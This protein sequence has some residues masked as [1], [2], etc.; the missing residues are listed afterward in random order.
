[1]TPSPV[2]PDP[3]G[4]RL[5]SVTTW[6]QATISM[7]PPLQTHLVAGGRSNLTYRITD[8]DGRR[9]ALR[10]PPA[11]RLLAT[12][13]DMTREWAVLRA[14]QGSDVPVA[15][16]IALCT[17]EAVTGAP[18]YVMAWMDGVVPVGDDAAAALSPAAAH[19]LTEDLADVL[20]AL[21][22]V[23]PDAVGLGDWRRPGDYLQR[24]LKRWHRQVHDSG[25]PDMA[26]VDSVHAELVARA[27]AGE[28]R[29]VHGDYRAGNVMV[30]LDGAIIAVLDWELATLGHPLAD[31]A[32]LL[33]SWWT[34]EGDVGPVTASP[35]RL[36]G[37][38]S[39][40]ELLSRYVQASGRNV[41]ALPIYEAF[42]RWR[43]ACI[44][45]GVRA[46]YVAGAMGSDDY[47]AQ[48]MDDRARE[49]LEAAAALL[50]RM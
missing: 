40:E 43:S 10:R 19:R 14:L 36:P 23:D 20:A 18:F 6:L 27:P 28:D 48:E 44:S 42:A 12:A 49:Q 47:D 2:P 37:V 41:D 38:G 45:A 35:A 32:W 39:R 13:H 50:T 33:T 4:L 3:P 34:R 7:Q 17:D 16:P 9:V 22:G 31:L 21:H 46:R 8:A 1:V 30:G 24:Q 11:G 29:I 26:L 25:C 5:S 15:T